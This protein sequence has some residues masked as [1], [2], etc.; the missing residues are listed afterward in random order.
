VK[1]IQ[2]T[3]FD[4]ER[5]GVARGLKTVF[6]LPSTGSGGGG[7]TVPASPQNA[8]TIDLASGGVTVT[9]QIQNN[10]GDYLYA[11]I[12]DQWFSG[13]T[14]GVTYGGQ[15]LTKLIEKSYDGQ[16]VGMLWGRAAPLTGINTLTA[17]RTTNGGFFLMGAI[18]IRG[19]KQTGPEGAIGFQLA[20][21][22]AAPSTIDVG[23]TVITPGALVLGFAWGTGS[24]YTTPPALQW[25]G[26]PDNNGGMAIST[27]EG[28]KAG[29]VTINFFERAPGTGVNGP[30]VTGPWI[31]FAVSHPPA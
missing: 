18:T 21:A 29:P 17:T 13:N 31:G 6:G 19:A 16:T 11:F 22:G 5:F 30:P 3:P 12:L 7:G 15:A 24:I 9:A 28:S 14:T 23:V 10:V 27:L 8:T 2:E 25:N 4:L 20:T 1:I 26:P